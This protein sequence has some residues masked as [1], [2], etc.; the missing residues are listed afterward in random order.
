MKTKNA[1]LILAGTGN[2]T[3]APVT[4]DG[5]LVVGKHVTGMAPSGRVM[6][7]AEEE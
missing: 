6:G 3:S 7:L 2:G 4:G 5:E 1:I